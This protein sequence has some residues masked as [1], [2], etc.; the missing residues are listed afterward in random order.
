MN[1]FQ[2]G[3]Y[4]I[5]KMF[6]PINRFFRTD[7]HSFGTLLFISIIFFVIGFKDLAIIISVYNTVFAHGYISE[8][9]SSNSSNEQQDEELNEILGF[10]GQAKEAL[11][12][13]Q[14]G[15]PDEN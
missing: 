2:K 13:V 3:E 8:Q 9:S 4:V 14:E 15:E 12:E 1:P 6:S 10:M 7:M 11:E 5:E